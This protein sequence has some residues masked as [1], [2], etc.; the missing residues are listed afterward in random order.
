MRSTVQPAIKHHFP[1]DFHTKRTVCG[2][3]ANY[4]IGQ[5]HKHNINPITNSQYPRAVQ[6]NQFLDDLRMT[7]LKAAQHEM[8][9]EEM[10]W[11]K[12]DAITN[13]KS[14]QSTTKQGHSTSQKG[15]GC[16]VLNNTNEEVPVRTCLGTAEIM[17][18]EVRNFITLVPVTQAMQGQAKR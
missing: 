5:S 7:C 15:C 17:L 16:P 9:M 1:S 2:G 10:L 12:M 14:H 4:F 6:V 3:M 13:H 8:Y 18:R 11:A